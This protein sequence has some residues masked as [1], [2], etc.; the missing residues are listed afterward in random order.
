M[1]DAPKARC[2]PFPAIP[3]LFFPRQTA[4]PAAWPRFLEAAFAVFAHRLFNI[5]AEQAP[6]GRQ[7]MGFVA[8]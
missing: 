7:N 8:A 5:I 2:F 1:D 4:F 3:A 6:P